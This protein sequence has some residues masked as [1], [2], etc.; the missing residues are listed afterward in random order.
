MENSTRAGNV[1]K[2][3]VSLAASKEASEVIVPFC[4]ALMTPHLEYCVQLWGCQY[5][6]DMDLL[7]MSKEAHEHDQKFGVPQLSRQAERVE[8]IV[9]GEENRIISLG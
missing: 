4:S 3:S 6:K 8:G 7:E 5:K 2:Q 1:H 9:T